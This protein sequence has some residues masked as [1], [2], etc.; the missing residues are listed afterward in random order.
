MRPITFRC[1]ATLPLAPEVI[2][3]QILDLTRWPEFGGYGP[4]P[5]I[6]S[7]EFEAHL[8]EV[9]GTRIR[10]TNRDGSSHVEEVIEWNPDRRVRLRM[11]HFSAPLSRLAT[12]FVETWEFERNGDETR[13]TR[14]FELHP[15]GRATRPVVWLTPLLLRR[16]VARHLRQMRN[17]T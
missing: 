6:R 5:G 4:L 2:A 10:V 14:S 3:G 9:V 17:P 12:E 1:E 7:A 16:A 13:V 15:K 8:P 11:S